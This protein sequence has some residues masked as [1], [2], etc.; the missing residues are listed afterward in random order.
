MSFSTAIIL[1][2][3]IIGTTATV[4]GAWFYIRSKHPP[5]GEVIRAGITVFIIITGLVGIATFISFST[6]IIINGQKN[7]PLPLSPTPRLPLSPTP[8]LSVPA[9]TN[10]TA[11][12]T[13]TPTLTAVPRRG[14]TPTPAPIPTATL[15]STPTLTAVPTQTPTPT[16]T[17][18]P[19]PTLMP[20]PTRNSAPRSKP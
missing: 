2:G 5:K 13:P 9:I 15:T 1:V 10:P 18:T 20:V 3:S 12:L 17:L 7:I 19:T 14:P 8:G 4:L 11:A 16:A 6:T